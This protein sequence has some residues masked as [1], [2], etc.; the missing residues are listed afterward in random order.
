MSKK[1][2]ELIKIDKKNKN[3]IF[4]KESSKFSSFFS[5][6]NKTFLLLTLVISLTLLTAGVFVATSYVPE[7]SDMVIKEVSIDTDID[8]T[9]KDVTSSISIMS[10]EYAKAMF[11]NISS[12]KKNGEALL[13]KS[14]SKG[15]YIINFESRSFHSQ[16]GFIQ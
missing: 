8:V 6:Y 7:S 5:K 4:R 14:V 3:I 16:F 12:F 1:K 2:I 15:K 9:S 13:V 10:D 11:Q